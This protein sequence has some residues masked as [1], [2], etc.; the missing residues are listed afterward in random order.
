MK[1]KKQFIPVLTA[2]MMFGCSLASY[3]ASAMDTGYGEFFYEIVDS[4]AIINGCD[5]N[6]TEVEIPD[7][8]NGYPVE[9]IYSQAFSGCTELT[10]V[11]IPASVTKIAR[12]AFEGCDALESFIVDENNEAFQ[13]IDGVLFNYSGTT[14]WCYPSAKADSVYTVPEGTTSMYYEGFGSCPNLTELVLPASLTDFRFAYVD[15][16]DVPPICT[17]LT[18]ITVAED[19]PNYQSI[20]GVLFSEDGLTLYR[21]PTGR[22]D[23]SYS[24]PEQVTTIGENAFLGSDALLS[25]N[26]AESLDVILDGAFY[27]CDNLQ[28]VD[29]PDAMTS[30][31][32]QAFAFCGNLSSIDLPDSL[33]ELGKYGFDSCTSLTELT[34]PSGLTAVSEGL[35]QNCSGLTSI[36][37]PENCTDI[38]AYAFYGCRSLNEITI[39]ASVTEIGSSA[40][41]NC[42]NL[43]DVY[44]G[45]TESEWNAVNVAMGND[46]LNNAVFH[47]QSDTDAS[48]GD[49][50]G[51]QIINASDAAVLLIAAAAAGSG[52]DSGL[53]DA[54]KTAADLNADGALDALD[55]ALILQYAAYV[56]TG[57]TMSLTDYLASL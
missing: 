54:Q 3:P 49:L 31:G 16:A 36:T 7:N 21:Y 30:I 45:G 12:N 33:T 46:K 40:F 29:L 8:I 25:V 24:V 11:S 47:Y 17:A 26:C 20:D 2:C 57:G 9:I 13:A 56:G 44:Y 22:A 51:N 53:T 6:V 23:E 39:P 27:S 19:N 38:A 5:R 50:D 15:S 41:K 37:I 10:S 48:F 42:L 18:A 32:M 52:A 34:L 43:T 55:A 28:S 14:L 1:L 35:L 4:Y